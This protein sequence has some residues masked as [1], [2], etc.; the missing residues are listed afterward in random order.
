MPGDATWVAPR[1]RKNVTT[2]ADIL[3][4]ADGHPVRDW[5]VGSP[6][7][8]FGRDAPGCHS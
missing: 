4:S 6:A 2:Q 3:V 7:P 1:C 8:P 5:P